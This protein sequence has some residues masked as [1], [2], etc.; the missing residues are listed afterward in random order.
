MPAKPSDRREPG[1]NRWRRLGSWFVSRMAW[2]WHPLFYAGIC[3][4][5]L[6]GRAQPFD[7]V[8]PFGIA[9]YMAVRAAGFSSAA[10]VPVAL[11]VMGGA[12]TVQPLPAFAASAAALGVVHALG[13]LSRLQARYAA[14]VAALVGSVAAAVQGVLQNPAADWIQLTFWAGLT[15]VLALIFTLAVEELTQPRYPE[16]LTADLP[17][18]AIILLA[19]AFTGLQDLTLWGRVSLHATAAGLAV[20]LFAQAGGLG[21]GAAAGAVIGMSSFLSVLASPPAAGAWLNPALTESHAMAYVIAGFLG[22]SFRELRKPGV[23]LSYMLGFLSYTMATQGQGAVLESMALSAVAATVL[24]W[25][26][27]S[28]W[29][30]R[31]SGAVSVRPR[32]Q[33]PPAGQD[34][35]D[36][37]VAGA[38]DQLRAMAQVLKE[39]QRTYTQ[40][41]AV[42]AGA[43]Q[44]PETRFRQVVETVCHSCSLY[45]QCW[46]KEPEESRRL[47]EGLWEQIENEGALPMAP[48][49]EQL[50]ARCVHPEQIVVTL[51]HVHDLERS[52]RALTRKLEEG[53][54]IA[55]EYVQNVARML[56]R[57]ADEVEAGSRD[58]QGLTAVFRATAAVARMPKRGG[59]ISGDSA[60]TGPLSRGRFL[61]ALSDGMGVGREAAVQS[62]ETVKLLQQLLDAG[63]NTEVAVRTVNSVLLLRGP[64]DSFATVDLAVLDLTTGR[65]EFVKVGAAPSFLKRGNDVTLVKMPSVPVGIVTEIEVE[66][67]FRNLRDGDIIVMVSDGILDVARDEADKER[68]VLEHLGR[69]QTADPEELAERLL[70]RALDLTPAPEDDLTVVVA[71]VD[72]VDGH[73]GGERPRPRVTGEWVP[74]QPAPRMKPQRKEDR[75]ERGRRR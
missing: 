12:A 14:L 20:M 34:R 24:F 58:H 37:V 38:R 13:G 41:A 30:S 17:I 39:I 28:R 49:P 16:G 69:E 63:F 72:Q 43:A 56:D 50:E 53:R 40:V 51:N 8:A 5:F 35:E 32:A 31:L 33:N 61:L 64:G 74:A 55:G 10:G 1:A 18:P 66:P 3:L 29:I 70:A 75:G 7:P 60:V 22:G 54:A 21:W 25:I 46:Q 27:P 68:W 19:A 9:F 36:A 65:A 62:G 71:R 23:G 47:F 52:G 4:G 11:A 48:L 67:E 2:A 45:A 44:E 15:G 42:S 57:M 73:G 6:M 59:H 26:I